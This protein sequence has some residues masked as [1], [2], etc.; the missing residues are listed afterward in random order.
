MRL[1]HL[2]FRTHDVDALVAFLVD[3]LGLPEVKDARPRSVWL[4]LSDGSVVMVERAG[5]DEPVMPGGSLELAAFEV[6]ADE[7]ARIRE[8]SL[9]RGCFDGETAHTVYLRAPDGRRIGVST[10]PLP[11]R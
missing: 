6:G 10:Y 4:G 9:R 5:G 7:K 2:A 1:H 11:G 3:L 8:E